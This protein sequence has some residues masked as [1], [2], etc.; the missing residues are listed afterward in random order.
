M[1]PQVGRP[2]QGA[3]DFKNFTEVEL[4]SLRRCLDL[5]QQGGNKDPKLEALIGYLL[6]TCRG[7]TQ[8]WL[9]LGCILF[10]QY[11]DTVRWWGRNWPSG[12]NSRVWILASTPVATVPVFGVMEN[13]ATLRPE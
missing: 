13:F 4:T 8:R 12:P 3:S 9:D 2:P 10:S 11:Y 6:G 5:L 1:P 7:V